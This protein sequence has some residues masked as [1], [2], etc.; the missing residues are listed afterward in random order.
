MTLFFSNQPPFRSP[1]SPGVFL[2]D[3]HPC[4]LPSTIFLVPLVFFR[5]IYSQYPSR[6]RNSAT[7]APLVSRVSSRISSLLGFLLP[8]SLIVCSGQARIPPP[9][10]DLCFLCSFFLTCTL[11]YSSGRRRALFP[12]KVAPQSFLF[13]SLSGFPFLHFL[14][15]A[16]GQFREIC[17]CPP[18]IIILS[19]VTTA[20]YP[21]LSC[22][23]PF[24]P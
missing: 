6:K 24:F 8:T 3:Q 17:C 10:S 13:T 15:E 9:P 19:T 11:T 21:L 1:T 18:T 16:L 4:V 22:V 5:K 23:V 7:P 14:G 20:L 12:Q 2:L